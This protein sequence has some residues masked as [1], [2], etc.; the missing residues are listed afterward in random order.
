MADPVTPRHYA[1]VFEGELGR[2]VLDDIQ[3]EGF[4]YHRLKKGDVVDEGASVFRDGARSLAL[5]IAERVREGRQAREP[6]ELVAHT[7]DNPRES[8][9]G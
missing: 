3:R 9:H 2:R 1:E 8:N 5:W 7:T 6:L 4:V